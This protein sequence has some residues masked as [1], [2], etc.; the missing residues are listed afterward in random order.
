MNQYELKSMLVFIQNKLAMLTSTCYF[1][2]EMDMTCVHKTNN[3]VMS[4]MIKM[5][6][7]VV[8]ND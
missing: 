8:W 7:M 6:V 2:V 5:L 1:L 3:L 4:N